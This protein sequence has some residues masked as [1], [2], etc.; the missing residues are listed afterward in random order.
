[1]AALNNG[2]VIYTYPSRKIDT[3]DD[4][5]EIQILQYQPSL[6]GALNNPNYQLSTN[7]PNATQQY[8]NVIPLAY[9]HLPIPQSIRD[10][11]SVTWGESSLNSLAAAAVTGAKGVIDSDDYTK[12]VV[13]LLNKVLGGVNNLSQSGNVQNAVGTAIAA[14]AVNQVGGNIDPSELLTRAT[15][16]IVNP[17]MELLFKTVQLRSCN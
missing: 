1:M 14:L 6:Q 12:G 15:G 5:L 16:Q 8:Q 11:N 3:S 2:P 4:Y 9:I 10:E 17:N 13:G 7:I